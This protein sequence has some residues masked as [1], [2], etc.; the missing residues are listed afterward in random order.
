MKEFTTQ[1]LLERIHCA[2]RDELQEIIPAV[3]ERFRELWPEWD[4]LVIS[5]EGRTSVDHIKTLEQC[6]RLMDA[7]AKQDG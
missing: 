6:I 7:V 1:A 2:D 5:C 3:T 4:L